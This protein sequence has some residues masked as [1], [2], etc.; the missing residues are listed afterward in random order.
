M[1]RPFAALLNEALHNRVLAI[2]DKGG[3]TELYRP[4]PTLLLC[5]IS[6]HFTEHHA[7]QLADASTEAAARD[8]VIHYFSDWEMMDAY[9]SAAR[10]TMTDW[11]RRHRKTLKT[12][13][14][15]CGNRIVE[16]GVNVAGTAMAF[17]G[18]KIGAVSRDVFS[19]GLTERLHAA[20]N[21]NS[22]AL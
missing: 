19:Q 15:I 7:R 9:D 14:F 13:T 21:E 3:T 8:A 11:G 17:L 12:G 18:I 20:Q 16:M 5:R 2:D 1:P 22:G 4:A 6:G 10:T